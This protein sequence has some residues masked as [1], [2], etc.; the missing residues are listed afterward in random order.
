[1]LAWLVSSFSY[2]HEELSYRK[3]LNIWTEAYF[4]QPST[5]LFQWFLEEIVFCFL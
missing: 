3:Q 1:M 4:V 5:E 2:R